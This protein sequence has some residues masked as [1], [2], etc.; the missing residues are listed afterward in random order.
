MFSKL[1]VKTFFSIIVPNLW[2][3]TVVVGF[4]SEVQVLLAR[5]T[6][7][8][9]VMVQMPG[10]E[11]LSRWQSSEPSLPLPPCRCRTS[12]TAAAMRWSASPST[13]PAG[14]SAGSRARW[15][16][17]RAC[18]MRTL[19]ATTTPGL[20]GTS[21]RLARARHARALGARPR[22]GEPCPGCQWATVTQTAPTAWRP[23]PRRPSSRARWNGARPGSALP[24][25]ASPPQ[26][27]APAAKR[28][29]MKMSTT[30]SSH[31][32]TCKSTQRSQ[33]AA[34]GSPLLEASPWS[35]PH[36]P[37]QERGVQIE[38]QSCLPC[39]KY[40]TKYETHFY[41]VT[42]CNPKGFFHYLQKISKIQALEKKKI[43]ISSNTLS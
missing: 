10:R 9:G 13:Q 43:E 40:T 2:I 21:G 32:P 4:P 16:C 12:W 31:S 22:M 25:P 30:V 6:V 11:V 3:S 17:C 28:T 29:M 33:Q 34:W 19:C 23:P 36:K 38:M 20:R 24:A 37:T 7:R 14:T 27:R 5:G 18:T 1:S 8:E 39:Q 15:H 35:N 41:R 26:A 42:T